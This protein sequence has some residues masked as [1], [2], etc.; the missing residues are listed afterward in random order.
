[1]YLDQTKFHKC[2][3]SLGSLTKNLIGNNM[4]EKTNKQTKQSPAPFWAEKGGVAQ[5]HC[6]CLGTRQEKLGRTYG[7]LMVFTMKMQ[8]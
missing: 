2:F 8:M 5:V 7:T 3:N 1:M 6:E 4:N